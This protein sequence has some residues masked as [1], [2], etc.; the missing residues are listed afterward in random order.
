[1]RRDHGG[2]GGGEVAQRVGAAGPHLAAEVVPRDPSSR[3]GEVPDGAGGPAG[4]GHR[5][6]GEQEHRERGEDHRE[7]A[8]VRGGLEGGRGVL[9]GDHLPAERRHRRVAGEDV[10]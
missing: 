10:L 1:G 9:G 3:G 8:H 7:P 2:G 6:G 5:G 4:E